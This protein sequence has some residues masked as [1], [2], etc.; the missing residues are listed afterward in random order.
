M[1]KDTNIHAGIRQKM[2]V[3]L[4]FLPEAACA[5]LAL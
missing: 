5:N 1:I 3:R 2:P 4:S